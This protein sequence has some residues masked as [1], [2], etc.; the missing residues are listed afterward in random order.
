MNISYQDSSVAIRKDSVIPSLRVGLKVVAEYNEI[1]IS[2]NAQLYSEDGKLLAPL[3]A[4]NLDLPQGIVKYVHA[5]HNS[6]WGNYTNQRT[7]CSYETIAIL[8]KES[9]NYIE[10]LREK[11]EKND[12]IFH[13]KANGEAFVNYTILGD[14]TTHLFSGVNP[15]QG[16][17]L[18]GNNKFS[19]DIRILTTPTGTSIFSINKCELQDQIIKIPSS[20]WINDFQGP[21]GVGNF[22]I[23]EIPVVNPDDSHFKNSPSELK[24]LIERVQSSRGILEKMKGYLAEGEWGRVIEESRKFLELFTKDVKPSIKNI[25]VNS[26]GISDESATKLTTALDNLEDYSNSLHHS[27]KRDG[28]G[29]AKISNVFTGGK[30]DAL[31]V[32]NLCSSIFNL[33]SKKILAYY[34]GE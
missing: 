19:D 5:I 13:L 17:A 3:E 12:V 4:I 6:E 20:D 23:I 26:T 18:A 11:N 14:F 33:I 28:S 22:M 9:V 7:T 24:T 8:S 29:P 27:T 2:V 25:V 21:L 15:P 1:P 16:I 34:G 30:E 31:L 32:F 10:K